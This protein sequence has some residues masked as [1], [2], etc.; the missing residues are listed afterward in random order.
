MVSEDV[1]H[2]KRDDDLQF[3]GWTGLYVDRAHMYT[4]IVKVPAC[5]TPQIL[6]NR[7][8]KC[9][10]LGK[11]HVWR[12]CYP[13]SRFIAKIFLGPLCQDLSN[14]YVGG[15]ISAHGN[16]WADKRCP[17]VVRYD[18]TSSD[19]IIDVLILVQVWR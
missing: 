12:A 19:T 2:S 16:L 14:E 6:R 18:H 8:V 10:T 9:L 4:R 1:G 3:T 5:E 15:N 13:L 17:C 7:R 11:P